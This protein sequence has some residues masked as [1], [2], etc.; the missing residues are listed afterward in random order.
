[1]DDLALFVAER[2][3]A[4]FFGLSSFEA[5]LRSHLRMKVIGQCRW[6]DADSLILLWRK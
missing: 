2:V 5:R 1:M 4:R 3:Q 6:Y